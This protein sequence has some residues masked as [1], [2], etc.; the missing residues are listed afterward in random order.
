MAMKIRLDIKHKKII[1]IMIK[2]LSK[3][4]TKV[5]IM[6]HNLEN[7]MIIIDNIRNIIMNN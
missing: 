7:L 6:N 3:I 2:G 5:L 1:I 4:E